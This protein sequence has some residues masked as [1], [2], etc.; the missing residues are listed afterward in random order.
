[1][2]TTREDQSGNKAHFVDINIFLTFGTV[3][4]TRTAMT[5]FDD[6]MILIC[7]GGAPLLFIGITTCCAV[8]VQRAFLVDEGK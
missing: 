6:G 1:M 3:R 4:T 2:E 8:V 7:L 5:P